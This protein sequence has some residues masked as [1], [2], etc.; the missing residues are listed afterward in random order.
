M[1]ISKVLLASLLM[2]L[3]CAGT[4]TAQINRVEYFID[5]DPGFGQATAIPVNAGNDIADKAASINLSAVTTG[6]HNF[7]IRSR[8]AS[9]SWSISN[10]APFFKTSLIAITTISRFEYFFDIDPG[11][12]QGTA[13]N[14]ATQSDVNNQ[15]AAINLSAI[16]NG[17][18]NLYIRSRDNSGKWSISNQV[19]FFKTSTIAVPGIS[20]VEYFF[21][22]DPG[23]GKGNA[24]NVAAQSNVNDQSAAIDLSTISNG[25]H[26]LYIRSRDNGGKWSVSNQVTFFKT[27]A[28]D[29]SKILKAEYYIDTDP[30]FGQAT[31]VPVTATSDLLNNE[32]VINLNGLSI[33]RHSFFFRTLDANGKWS[34]TNTKSFLICNTAPAVSKFNFNV[35][36]NQVFFTNMS[37]SS[38]S[39]LWDFGDGTSSSALNPIK[40]YSQAGNY[41]LNLYNTNT[42]NTDTLTTMFSVAGLQRINATKGGNNGVATVILEGVGFTNSTVVKLQK[43]NTILLPSDKRFISSNRI[44]GYF[45]LTG[46][47]TGT[48][49]VVADMSGT[50]LDTIRNGFEIT[51]ARRPEV[52]YTDGGRNPSRANQNRRNIILQNSGNEDAIMVPFATMAGYKPGTIRLVS[53]ISFVGLEK[54]GIFENTYQYLSTKGISQDVMRE[55]DIDTSRKKQLLAYYRVKVPSES[56]VNS[57]YSISNSFGSLQYSVKN[58]IQPA[59]YRSGILL[60]NTNAD[61]GRDCMNSF[62]KKAVNKNII[63]SINDAGW[64]SCFNTAFDT[65]SKSIRDIAKDITLQ[66]RSIPMKSVYSTLLVQMLQCQ[67]SGMPSTIST[68]EFEKV[69]K[70]VTYN[71]LFLENLDSIG[72][73]CFDTTETFVFRE[74]PNV[75]VPNNAAYSKTITL[76]DDEC[77]NAAKFP[78]LADL[79][80]DFSDPCENVKRILFKDDDLFSQLG[81]HV[82]DKFL[83]LLGPEGSDG[84]CGL[85]SATKGCKAFCEQTSVDPNVKFGPGDNV[86]SKHVNYLSNYAYSIFFENLASATASAA[87]V[88]IRDTLDKAKFDISTFQAGSFGWGDSLVQ[89]DAN[90][91]DYSLL[92]DLQPAH[93]NKLRADV[94]IDTATGV[95]VWKFSTLDVNTLQLT[96]NPAEGFLPPNTDGKKGQGFV[97]FSIKPKQGVTSGT[98]VNNKAIIVFDDNAAITTGIWQHIIDTTMPES[99]VVALAEN[100]PSKDFDVSWNGSDAHAGIGS[101]T[102]YV[103]INDSLYTEWLSSTTAV[104]GMYHGEFGNSYKFI[105]VAVD[106]AGN[107]EDVA[108]KQTPDAQTIPLATGQVVSIKNGLWSQPSTWSSNKVPGSVNDVLVKH[109]VTVD[110]NGN[111]KSLKAVKPG[112]VHINAGIRLDLVGH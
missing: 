41:T 65:L 27:G 7:F 36:G 26:N 40:T 28:L 16:S 80:K 82:F 98:I 66:D 23:F 94:S 46:A 77:P 43:A 57:D 21:D 50:P 17:F 14:T 34:I 112:M 69:I 99:K 59:L 109:Q 85:N 87:Y 20:R 67:A 53:N 89:I 93:P 101:Y 88:E 35:E 9:G 73:P 60:N 13:I 74:K 4:S 91:N 8:D 61:N 78:E 47:Q 22:T 11:F 10:Q 30:G 32:A 54:A 1:Q 107:Y 86:N 25:F 70:D 15:A 55:S 39:R 37:D 5:L 95:V 12:G 105:S 31:A 103:S 56:Y 72:R 2:I 51:L 81:R 44:V 84:F 24:I 104:N 92:K 38:N 18:H 29:S 68:V 90:R 62:L 49:N 71:W 79:C 6:I 75:V 111:C 63:V 3:L 96:T 33:G 97:N 102:V 100:V 108:G 42:C 45:N 48:Y 58:V 106:K 76:S 110:I 64:N 52:S 19:A 83:D